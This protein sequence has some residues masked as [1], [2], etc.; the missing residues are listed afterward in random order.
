MEREGKL[1]S[2]QEGGRKEGKKAA[3]GDEETAKDGEKSTAE[4]WGEAR[5]NIDLCSMLVKVV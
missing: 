4:E 3:E 1:I 5:Q 2:S